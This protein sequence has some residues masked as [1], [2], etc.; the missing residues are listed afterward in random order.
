[1]RIALS[2]AASRVGPVADTSTCCVVTPPKSGL[3]RN[4]LGVCATAWL[5]A[6]DVRTHLGH[7]ERRICRALHVTRSSV[8]YVPQPRSDEAPLT[9]AVI[10]LAS[11]YGRYGYRRVHALAQA[12]GWFVS[13]SRV[14]RIWKREGLKGPIKQPKRGRL[15]LA[16]GSC[17]RLRPEYPHHVWSWDFVMERTHDGRVLKILVLI[18]EHTR[19]CLSLHVARQ[20]RSNDV[21]DV[22][23]DARTRCTGPSTLGQR[24]GDGGKTC[25]AGWQPQAPRR[26]TSN[27]VVPGR[28]VTVNRSMGS[29]AMNCSTAKSSIRYEKLR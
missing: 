6:V 9:Q 22:L 7:A 11:Q 28:T 4:G 23:A 29:S 27:R 13:R 8:R 15:W 21:I 25:V 24:P 17:I 18:D 12:Q 16:D 20:I 1:M 19:Q 14:E 26:C 2:T 10:M 5:D 3:V